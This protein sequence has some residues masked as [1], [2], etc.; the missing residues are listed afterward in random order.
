MDIKKLWENCLVE[1]E[2]GLSKANF[3]TWFKNTSIVKEDTGIIYVGVPNEFVRDWL[4]NKYHKL[5]SKTIAD[6]Y[7]NMRGVEY[8]ITK[9]EV[10]KQENQK[11]AEVY[12]N[13][14]LPLKD[15]YV[16]PDDNLNP[17][18]RFDS[19]IVGTFNELA[20]AASQAIIESP[21]TK[22]NPFFVYGNTGLGKTHLLQ[23][24]G[25]AIK[26]KDSNKKVHY[27]TL[28]KFATD[29]INSLQGN[30]ANT[31]KEK[32]RKYDLLIIDDIQFIGKMEKIQEELFH[33]FNTFYENNKQIVFSSDKHPNFIPELADRLKSRF[34]AGMIVDVSEP[35][36]ES[37]L[38]ILKVK[39][40]EQGIELEPEIIEYV[41]SIIR[42]NIR[43]LEG[44]L[45]I[46]VC[47]YRLKNKPLSLSEVKNILKNNIKPKKNVAIKDVV[48]L[49][50]DYYNLEESSIY[51][52][53]RR[54]EIVK[55]RQMVMYILRE[56]FNV[57]YPLIGQKLGGKDH[58]TVIHS[59]LKIKTDLKNDS[60]LLQELE[61]IRIMFK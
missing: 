6:A 18:Y 48:K 34:A 47:Q 37:R 43:E 40:Q 49:V 32:Y 2:S 53:T 30:R 3:S 7:E 50:S 61:A 36:Y 29:F 56:D 31:F 21:G 57:S 45:N 17:R 4:Q 25:N 58:T 33:T 55:A 28:E 35:E 59:Y 10:N 1:I 42:G 26:E 27:I 38:A 13:K 54:K 20:Y 52:K 39:L 19:F 51:E 5:I 44:S 14:E 41:A 11:S 12:V 22:Y 9:I 23:A 46:I 8:I 16:N 60:Q 15:L 24:V